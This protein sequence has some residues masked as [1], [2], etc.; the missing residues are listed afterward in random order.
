MKQVIVTGGRDY[1]DWDKIKSVLDFHQPDMV[2]QGGASGA[3][4][5]AKEWAKLN[6]KDF[7]TIE[8]DWQKHGRAAGPIRNRL[9]LDSYP[10]AFVIAF[11]GGRGTADCVRTANELNRIIFQVHK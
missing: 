7:V 10:D 6:L 11:P 3:D 2:I 1:I 5:L 4:K 8:A 9:M